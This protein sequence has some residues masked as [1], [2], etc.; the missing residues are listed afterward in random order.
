MGRGRRNRQV[1]LRAHPSGAPRESDFECVESELPPLSEGQ[2]LLR[3]RFIS[4]DAGFR[5]WMNEGAGDGYLEAMTLG[6]PVMGLVLGEVEESRNSEYG[7]G[8]IVMCRSRWE[9]RTVADGSDYINK[10]ALAPDVSPS[11]Y[12][13]ILGPTGLTAYFGLRDIGKV[14]EGDTVLI[15][16][17][18]GAV[19][20]VAAQI[21]KI[22]GGR[23]IGMTSTD[24]KCR[25]LLDELGIDGAINY[26]SEGGLAAGLAEK[27]PDGVDVYFDNVGGATLDTVL[28]HLAERA[29]VVLCGALATYNT[30][31]PVPGPYNMFKLIT[32]RA[33]MAGFMVTDYVEQYP[34]AIEQLTAWLKSGRLKN[35]ED[36]VVG[37]ENTAAAFCKMF[38]GGNR[39]KLV[40]RLE[41]DA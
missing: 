2:F 24:E 13:G 20:S 21:A 18:A 32:Q 15:S 6:E 23:V 29:R 9:E 27:C 8:D 7:V 4:L 28:A 33:T 17:A 25:W 38:A 16:T 22:Q 39:G 19:G 5:Q 10:L 31:E 1:L 36:V 37:I 34:Q 26:R 14:R 11:C 35:A 40:V 30:T 41:G 12:L 3:N